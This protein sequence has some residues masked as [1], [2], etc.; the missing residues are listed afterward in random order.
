LVA[1]EPPSTCAGSG[2]GLDIRALPEQEA[3]DAVVDFVASRRLLL[4][5]DSCEHL[6]GAAAALAD[7]LLRSAPQLTIVAR[8]REARKTRRTLHESASGSTACRWR[9]S[10][11]RAGSAP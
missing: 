4:V 5:L 1:F 7:A 3:L 11:Q 10:S 2:G 8:S 9:S 6:L